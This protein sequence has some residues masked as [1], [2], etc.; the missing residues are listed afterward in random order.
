MHLKCPWFVC[1]SARQSLGE[2]SW[3]ITSCN[4][5]Y[6]NMGGGLPWHQSQ[7]CWGKTGC[8]PMPCAYIY[9]TSKV[10]THKLCADHI[11]CLCRCG[12][13]LCLGA[14]PTLP[15]FFHAVFKLVHS[16]CQLI[17]HI[18]WCW[19]LVEFGRP[20]GTSLYCSVCS[21][22]FCWYGKYRQRVDV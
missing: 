5:R 14:P 3:S 19:L 21:C 15:G 4:C 22:P 1:G 6:P 11:M 16:L 2:P 13:L 18:F 10:L 8:H 7:A 12:F 9:C 17:I 20:F